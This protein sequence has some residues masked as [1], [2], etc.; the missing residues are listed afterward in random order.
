MDFSKNE[1]KNISEMSKLSTGVEITTLQGI[2]FLP[3]DSKRKKTHL[4]SSLVVCVSPCGF[5]YLRE[6]SVKAVQLMRD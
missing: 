2:F 1:K 5:R 4:L 6:I 3:L